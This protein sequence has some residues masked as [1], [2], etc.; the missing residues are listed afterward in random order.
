MTM[1]KDPTKK[2]ALAKHDATDR[3]AAK[4]SPVM[5]RAIGGAEGFAAQEKALS[6]GDGVQMKGRSNA[7]DTETKKVDPASG[8]DAHAKFA[9]LFSRVDGCVEHRG[10]RVK[11]DAKKALPITAAILALAQ[12]S[13][14]SMEE[15][16]NEIQEI[17]RLSRLLFQEK[18]ARAAWENLAAAERAL[19][20]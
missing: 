13:G 3:E 2:A 15:F 17:S 20:G 12:Q 6:P 7:H 14:P 1:T 19:I 8:A 4:A 9:G 10:D 11:V 16:Y 18:A 5:K